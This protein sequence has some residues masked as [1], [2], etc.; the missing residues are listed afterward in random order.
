MNKQTIIGL[1]LVALGAASYG[2]LAT[3]VKLGVE[4]GYTTAEM[5]F[6]Q[7][8]NGLLILSLMNLV[9]KLKPGSSTK[10]VSLKDKRN[11]ILSG[12]PF[13]LTST[14]Y[15]QSLN[16]TTVS[17]CIVMLMQSVWLGSVLDYFI[18]KT[19]PSKSKLAAIALVLVGTVM[20]TN[21]LS[22]KVDLDWRGIFWGFMAAISYT[23]T[24]S[25]TNNVATS[26]HPLTRSMFMLMGALITISIIWGYSIFQK[27]DISVFW[28]WGLIIAFFGT[29]IPPLLFTKGMPV[30]GLGLG[31]IIASVELPVSV[32]AAWILLGETVNI[33]QWAGIILILSAVVLMNLSYLK[34]AN[35][36]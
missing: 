15:Y 6:A 24:L 26:H 11:L 29:I 19:T 10:K 31:S 22:D 35:S 9:K 2:I 30:V 8:F 3:L 33:I 1:L 23:V 14:F 13:G 20:A 25:V 16:Y 12:I 4:D 32:F 27:F 21:L 5:T 17:V 28:R 18:N 34:T 7:A 36:D